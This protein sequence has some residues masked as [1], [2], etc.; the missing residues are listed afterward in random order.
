MRQHLNADG[1]S[2]HRKHEMEDSKHTKTLIHLL[3]TQLIKRQG[4]I[5]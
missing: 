5:K 1:Q 3:V 2:K 4:H